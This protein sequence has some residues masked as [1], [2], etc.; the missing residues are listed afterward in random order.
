[1]ANFA[2]IFSAEL[3]GISARTIE[4]EVDL[5]VG[6]HAFSI[7]GLA[8]RALNEAKER[9]NS[10]LKNSGAKPPN[11]ENRKITVNLAPADIKKKGSQ[12][13]LAIALGYLMATK[14][15]TPFDTKDKMFLG[16][17]A[18]DGRL[19]P[20]SG[21]LSIA[22][23][24]AAKGFKTL[25]LPQANAN[26]ASAV[27]N[28]VV[29][30]LDQLT[31]VVEI[32]ENRKSLT[33]HVFQQNASVTPQVPDFADIHGQ[34][35]AKRALM[36][37][38]AGRHNL[39][40]TGSPGIGKSLMAQALSG[41]FPEMTL[42]ESIEVTK[43]WSAAG[44]ILNGLVTGRPF[45]APHQTISSIAM[46][47]GGAELRPGEISLAHRGV[48]FLD[49]LPEFPRH[50]LE[51]L[52]GP[53]ETGWVNIARAKGNIR[54]PSRFSFVTAMNPCPCGWHGDPDKECLCSAREIIRYRK[55][56]SGPLLDRIDLQLKIPRLSMGSL[57]RPRSVEKSSAAIKEKVEVAHARQIR[58]FKNNQMGLCANADMTSRETE[59]MI[60][61]STTG[62]HFLEILQ[63]K[64]S[65]PRSYYRLLKTAR[66][67]ADLED[68]DEV[69][70]VD[71]AEAWSYRL[72]DDA[73]AETFNRVRMG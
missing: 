48:L 58:R 31:H 73:S 13:D 5:N 35:N 34:H 24:A 10:A 41:T 61:L 2:T 44:N 70:S 11:R 30:G 51:A 65:S 32:L 54:F 18:L 9:V 23:M 12:Y 60:H 49:E 29:V 62:N 42:Q 19:R 57:G 69:E 36:I 38:A 67:I 46:I 16:E 71:L 6:L 64:A 68:R 33:S 72:R 7:V 40:M 21:A 66:T 56:I 26:E 37:A 14:Q 39:L 52:R 28:I 45:R 1:V 8:D 43:I 55:K 47:G 17:L 20:V 53:I 4:I 27:R 63:K 3:E 22:E 15:M 25:F 50:V 59:K